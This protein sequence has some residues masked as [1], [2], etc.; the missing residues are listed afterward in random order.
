MDAP[1][2][3]DSGQEQDIDVESEVEFEIFTDEQ[4]TS[5]NTD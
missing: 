4:D 1:D 3:N 5:R 2:E